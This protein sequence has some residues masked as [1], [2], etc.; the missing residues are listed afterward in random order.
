MSDNGTGVLRSKR[1]AQLSRKLAD[2][3]NIGEIQLSSHKVGRKEALEK[4]KTS[5]RTSAIAEL[6]SEHDDS[7]TILSQ[8][9]KKTHTEGSNL[10][11]LV[12]GT[13]QSN[14]ELQPAPTYRS[15]RPIIEDEPE[16]EDPRLSSCERPNQFI[17]EDPN[18]TDDSGTAPMPSARSQALP[19]TPQPTCQRQPAQPP[20]PRTDP[21]QDNNSSDDSELDGIQEISPPKPQIADRTCDVDYFFSPTLKKEGKNVRECR[22]C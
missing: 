22:R 19:S 7:E 2:P 4:A 9:S 5:K 6:E 15:L 8:P 17:I 14:D 18:V 3:N 11:E 10:E 20:S 13:H 12:L 1:P 16:S 21:A